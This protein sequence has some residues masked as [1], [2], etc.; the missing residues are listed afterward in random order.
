M[1]IPLDKLSE[2]F[3]QDQIKSRKGNFGNQL[4]YVD[5]QTV[6]QR[7]AHERLRQTDGITLSSRDQVEIQSTSFC[8]EPI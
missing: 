7:L 2:A 8:L 5:S 3:P 1:S 6:T 4:S